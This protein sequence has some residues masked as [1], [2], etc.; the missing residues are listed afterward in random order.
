MHIDVKICGL[1]TRQALDAALAGGAAYVGFVF[2]PPSPRALSPDEAAPLLAQA[3]GRA[4]TV[5]LTVD[6]DTALL[7]AIVSRL[8][9]DLL[10]FH[11]SE[12][13]QHVIDARKKY[14]IPVMKAL[15]IGGREDIAAASA[16]EGAA[17]MLLFDA[18]PRPGEGLGLPG[19][20]GVTFDWRLMAGLDLTLPVMLSGG[21][22]ASNVAMAVRLSG[23]AAVDVSSGVESA[24][25]VK[26]VKLIGEF[27]AAVRNLEGVPA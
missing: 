4:K 23:A 5:A 16:Y 8:K 14:R 26:D 20:N 6:A 11:G 27:L 13:P 15:K 12:T 9:P 21:L 22:D 10:Q 24:P 17:D 19:G 25:G 7:D 2:Y 18:K 1:K 3:R